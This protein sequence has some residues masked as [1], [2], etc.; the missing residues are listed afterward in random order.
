MTP[1]QSWI[2]PRSQRRLMSYWRSKARVAHIPFWT[3]SGFQTHQN[4][5]QSAPCV[6]I[7]SSKFLARTSRHGKWLKV[8]W[9]IAEKL[10][11]WLKTRWLQS[12]GRAFTLPYIEMANLLRFFL[13]V[14]LETDMKWP[15]QSR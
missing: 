14:H 2:T 4:L 5:V 13:W 9:E 8:N 10:P 11:T 1:N 3:S 12:D 15:K 7:G 6:L